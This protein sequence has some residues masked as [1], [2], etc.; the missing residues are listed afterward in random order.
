LPIQAESWRKELYRPI[1]HVHK[2]WATRLGSVFRGILLGCQLPCNADLGRE[3]YR[4]H[5]FR[6]KV[7]FDPFMGS[8]TTIGEAYKLGYTAL[9]REINPVPVRAARVALGNLDKTAIVRTFDQVRRQVADSIKG[10]YKARDASGIVCDVLYY[11]W[12]KTTVC[13]GC[14]RRV[15]LFPSYIIARHASPSRNPAV[16]VVCPYCGRLFPSTRGARSESCPVCGG[17]FN[18]QQGPARN[19]NAVCPHCEFEFPIAKTIRASGKPP[20]HRLYG[21]LLLRPNGWISLCD[22]C[23]GAGFHFLNA[24]PVKSEMSVAT[25]K[26]QAK[27]PIDIDIILVCRK[28]SDDRRAFQNDRLAW[29]EAVR[30]TSQKADKYL[31]KP[32][33][34]SMNDMRILLISQLL[35]EFCP[36]RSVDEVYDYLAAAAHSIDATTQVL[37]DQLQETTRPCSQSSTLLDSQQMELFE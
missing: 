23:M 5:D 28:D 27:E 9:G 22:A 30:K 24:H 12:V 17:R 18:P 26:S 10:L 13:P 6:G 31:K 29:H 21:K 7:V 4:R 20:E 34:F 14:T 36:S 19:A 35:I 11:F 16:Q 33:R 2:W 8:G 32:R 1:Y 15:D 37:F 3:F 25:P